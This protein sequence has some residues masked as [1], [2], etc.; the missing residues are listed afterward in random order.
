MQDS[1]SSD[2]IF[3]LENTIISG[4]GPKQCSIVGSSIGESFAGNLIKQNDNCLG[5]VTSLDPQLGPLQNNP[6]LTPTMAI[7]KSSPAKQCGR[8]CH[9]ALYRPARPAAACAR[10]GR[11]T[12]YWGI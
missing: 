4:N 6:G 11:R 2:T 8:S 10:H 5:V 1:S 3:A 7:P 12:R 9:F